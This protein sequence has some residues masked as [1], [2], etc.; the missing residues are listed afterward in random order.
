M[1]AEFLPAVKSG[2]S[3]HTA[4]LVHQNAR[5]STPGLPALEV[6]T[7]AEIGRHEEDEHRLFAYLR[8]QHM[9]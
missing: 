4:Y 3:L 2:T 6:P 5:I 7:E 9:L 8:R 1:L